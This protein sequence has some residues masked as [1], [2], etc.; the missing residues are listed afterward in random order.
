MERTKQNQFATT[1]HR[2]L[3]AGGPLVSGRQMGN[4]SSILHEKSAI[5]YCFNGSPGWNR[6]NDQR[7]NREADPEPIVP[8][9][10][11]SKT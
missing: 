4:T 3:E 9:R 11:E 1:Y 6:T 5:N 7:S 10:K 2:S 8:C